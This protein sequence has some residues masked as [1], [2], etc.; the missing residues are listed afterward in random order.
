LTDAREALGKSLD[1]ARA[2][3]ASYEEAVTLRVL[4]ALDIHVGGSVGH[5][6]LGESDAIFERLGVVSMPDAP[7][8]PPHI[9]A[10]TASS[11]SP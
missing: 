2:R 8:L 4:A 7:L 10:E 11:P 6:L 3:N 9:S 1:A 5:A